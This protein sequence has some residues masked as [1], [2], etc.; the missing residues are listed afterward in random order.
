M[1]FASSANAA[2]DILP[3]VNILIATSTLSF[4][5][6]S[7]LTRLDKELGHVYTITKVSVSTWDPPAVVCLYSETSFSKAVTCHFIWSWSFADVAR[8]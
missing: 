4:H 2:G 6:P 7:N 8:G 1:M 3:V 5:N